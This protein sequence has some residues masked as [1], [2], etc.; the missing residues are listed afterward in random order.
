VSQVS[1]VATV[2]LLI[3]DYA[4][5][6]P[7]GKLTVVG[8]LVTV[9]AANPALVDVTAPFWLAMWISVPPEHYGARCTVEMVLED[10]SGH[11]VTF[12]DPTGQGDPIRITQEI[13]FP[14]PVLPE[15]SSDA[16]GTLPARAHS[17]VAFSVGLPLEAEKRYTWRVKVDGESREDWTETFVVISQPATQISQ[18][19]NPTDLAP[20]QT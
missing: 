12:P 4:A 13:A 16:S 3:A 6:D 8:G 18:P 19:Q 10:S 11:P 14:R 20:G 5:V 7:S 2:R 17:V 15:P 9:L 1:D